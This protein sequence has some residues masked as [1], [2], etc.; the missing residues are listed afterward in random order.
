MEGSYNTPEERSE[1]VQLGEDTIAHL[2]NVA[3]GLGIIKTD[4][5]F[6]F[7]PDIFDF[8][9]ILKMHIEKRKK[10]RNFRNFLQE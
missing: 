1:R 8:I 3:M 10:N 9:R 2:E 7:L 6:V 5:F 4:L